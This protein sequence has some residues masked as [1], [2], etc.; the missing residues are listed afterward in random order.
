M[1]AGLYFDSAKWFKMLEDRGCKLVSD[2]IFPGK[3]QDHYLWETP[4]GH[5]FMAPHH[6]TYDE[7]AEIIK[8]EVDGTKPAIH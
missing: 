7:A 6:C 3:T 4:W 2:K 8:R 1:I 5:K